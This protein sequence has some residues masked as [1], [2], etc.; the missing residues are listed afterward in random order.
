MAGVSVPVDVA[1]AMR[2]ALELIDRDDRQFLGRES[3][4][5]LDEADRVY[6]E[7]LR[8]VPKETSG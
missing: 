2:E 3:R 1:Q 7:W 6:R 4:R 8:G 5:L